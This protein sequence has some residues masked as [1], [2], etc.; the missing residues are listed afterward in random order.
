MGSMEMMAHPLSILRDSESLWDVSG[1][2]VMRSS[3][4]KV[5]V[6]IPSPYLL[7]VSRGRLAGFDSSKKLVC[8]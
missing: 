2:V 7:R 6:R 5:E 1:E 8:R 4:A 3:D